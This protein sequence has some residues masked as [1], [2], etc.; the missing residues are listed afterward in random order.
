M[1][2]IGFGEIRIAQRGI[3]QV[4]SAEGNSCHF[5]TGQTAPLEKDTRR[6]SGRTVAFA[7]RRRLADIGNTNHEEGDYQQGHHDRPRRTHP[8]ALAQRMFFRGETV[9]I[10]AHLQWYHLRHSAQTS[11]LSLRPRARPSVSAAFRMMPS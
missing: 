11:P 6:R 10:G 9:V 8:F 7:L 2:Q 4:S 3:G 1:R 5:D